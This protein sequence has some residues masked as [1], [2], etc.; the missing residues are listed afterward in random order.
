MNVA[1]V[2]PP[3]PP[4]PPDRTFSTLAPGRYRL[5]VLAHGVMFEIARIRRERDQLFGELSVSLDNGNGRCVNGV[6]SVADFNLSGASSRRDRAKLLQERSRRADVDWPGHLEEFAQRILAAERTGTPAV[7]LHTL[8]RPTPADI[9]TLDNFPL[10]RRHPM[11]L[12]GDG[13]TAKSYFAL[14]LAGCLAK[15]GLTVLYADW[16]LAGEEHRDRLERLFGAQMPR[17]LYARCE[18]P[19]TVEGDRLVRIIQDEKVGF[20]ICDSIAVACDGPPESAEAAAAYFRM[21]RQFNTGSL[22][23]AHINRGEQAEM[24]PFG[25]SFWHNLARSTWFAKKSESSNLDTLVLGLFQRK[26]NLGPTTPPIAFTL[27][28]TDAPATTRV[29]TATINDYDDLRAAKPLWQRMADILERRGPQTPAELADD[30]GAKEQTVRRLARRLPR[31]FKSMRSA[32]S[33]IFKIGLIP[34]RPYFADDTSPPVA[35]APTP[36]S[37][38]LAADE[39]PPPGDADAPQARTGRPKNRRSFTP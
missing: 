33:P 32:D 36:A 29:A 20:V 34:A 23:I 8:D 7:E 22:H 38:P 24:K 25:S 16:E 30:L 9:W 10:L 18:R 6:L 14:Y 28:F 37:L 3:P 4:P 39:P 11:I 17:I 12:F 1:K 2:A 27:G 21:V 31:K 35:T 26:A 13:G 15:Q 19:L 5:G